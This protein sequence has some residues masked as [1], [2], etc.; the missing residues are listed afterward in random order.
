M[1]L[2]CHLTR[3]L[4]RKSIISTHFRSLNAVSAAPGDVACSSEIFA[5]G[6]ESPLTCGAGVPLDEVTWL[7]GS[8][9]GLCSARSSDASSTCVLAMKSKNAADLRFNSFI[10][11][12]LCV[13]LLADLALCLSALVWPPFVSSV[14]GVSL[15]IDRMGDF[16]FSSRSLVYWF[17][18]FVFL[19]LRALFLWVLF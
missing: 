19:V 11:I 7:A 18:P 1:Y 8:A 5:P 9:F 10:E 4:V 3:S 6:L 14:R 15:D 13:V 12:L 2:F 16:S 17:R